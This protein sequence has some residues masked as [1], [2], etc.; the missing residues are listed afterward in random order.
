MKK[1]LFSA[2][3]VFSH[4]FGFSQMTKIQNLDKECKWKFHKKGEITW[5]DATVPGTIHT[6]LLNNKK[7]EDPFYG[8]NE[9]KL[10]WIE[11][12]I[13]EYKTSFKVKPE[14]MSCKHI[15]ITFEGLDTYAKVYLNDSLIINADNMFRTWKLDVKKHLRSGTN[16]LLIVFD[17]AVKIGKEKASKLT[18]TLPGDEKVFTRK[19]QYQYGWD[20]G[21]RFVTCGIW[22]PFYLEG[23]DF[24][25]IENVQVV[26][27]S[28]TEKEAKM[29]GYVTITSEISDFHML[30]VKNKSNG[31]TLAIL[32]A[33]IEIGTKEYKMSFPIPN[34][35]LWWCNG[36]GKPELYNLVFEVRQK[37]TTFCSK[38]VKTG[39]RTLNLFQTKDE[40][41]KSFYFALNGT[42]VFIKGANYIPQDNFIPSRE[43]KDYK[44]LIEDAAKCNFNMLRVWGG[45]IYENDDFYNYCDENGILVWQD[46][47]FACAM[48]PADNEFIKNVKQE[49]TDNVKRLRNHP[50]IALWCGNNEID[51]GWKNWGWQKL[52]KYSLSDSAKIW[53]DY[54]S[55]FLK[56]IPDVLK[57]TDNSR[58]YW[59]SSPSIGWGKKE[60]LLSGD[61][62]YWGVWWGNEPF[63]TYKTKVGRF[64]SEYGFQGFPDIKTIRSFL[65]DSSLHL[66]S[67]MLKVHEKHPVGFNTIQTY[68]EQDYKIP[69][70]FDD[71]DYVSQLLQ[72]YGM[73]TAIEAHRKAKPYC[74]GTLYWQFNDCWPVIS[75]SSRDYYGRWKASQYFVKNLYK[76]ILI[77]TE[78][79]KDHIKIS[80]VNDMINKTLGTLKVEAFD[81]SGKKLF[82]KDTII[83]VEGN[84]SKI[85]VSMCTVDVISNANILG[86]VVIRSTFTDENKNS[87]SNL[88]YFKKPKDLELSKPNIKIKLGEKIAEKYQIHIKSDVLAKNVY[89]YLDGYDAEFSDNF[90]DVIPGDDVVIECKVE[91][92]VNNFLGSLKYKVLNDVEFKTAEIK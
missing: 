70:K 86:K 64:M 44:K 27:N 11:N 87:Y 88:Y 75:W 47:M 90:F 42:P 85:F 30:M 53:G 81:F 16:N 82:S 48:Y 31:T 46:F 10:Q 50:C 66:N 71:Y 19:A 13:W 59:P 77:V 76:N 15:E 3:F 36:L 74:M 5:L 68:M 58:A 60:S 32:N 57:Q 23:W 69:V 34:P 78:E 73:K 26:T 40:K 25:K 22:K 84:S 62:H 83:D 65:P 54:Q 43:Q 24:M 29:T 21:P 38:E 39:I 51:E 12:E 55:L 17:P 20:W 2:I 61:C 80:I 49:V 4:I 56:A 41:G 14:I 72:A 1:I 37:K 91:T 18:Y 33:N 6:D 45:G 7:I 28:Y 35:K 92:D 67:E 9:S 8:N 89:L 79:V 52:Y 63:E